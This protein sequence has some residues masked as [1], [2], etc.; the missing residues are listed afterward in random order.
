MAEFIDL[1]AEIRAVIS[2]KALDRTAWDAKSA[3]GFEVH[4]KP[5][6]F[7]KGIWK[8]FSKAQKEHFCFSE[9]LLTL[10]PSPTA[11]Q[12]TDGQPDSKDPQNPVSNV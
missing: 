4:L 12:F 9:T 2:L 7:L 1:I 6:E 11:C 3:P 8:T 10:K 5:Q